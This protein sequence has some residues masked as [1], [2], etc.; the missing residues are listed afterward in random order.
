MLS[1]VQ[2]LGDREVLARR[3][4]RV[5]MAGSVPRAYVPSFNAEEGGL[6]VQDVEFNGRGQPLIYREPVRRINDPNIGYSFI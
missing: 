6:Q 4:P 5:G 1:L 3:K 2:H